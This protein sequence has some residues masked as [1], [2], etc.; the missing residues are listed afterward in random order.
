MYDDRRDL[1]GDLSW[2]EVL[3]VVG[4]AVAILLGSAYIALKLVG[5]L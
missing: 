1:D 3:S 4:L 2:L 5:L